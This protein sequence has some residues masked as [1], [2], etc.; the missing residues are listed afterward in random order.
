MLSSATRLTENTTTKHKFVYVIQLNNGKY[1]V[2]TSDKPYRCIAKINS[3][4]HRMIPE[5]QTVYRVVGI[6]DQTE[7]RNLITTVKKISDKAGIENTITL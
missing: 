4:M 2:G 7:D 5:K 1:C 3:G 6:K